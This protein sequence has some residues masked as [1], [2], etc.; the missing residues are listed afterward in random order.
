MSLVGLNKSSMDSSGPHRVRGDSRS[1][2]NSLASVDCGQT[3]NDQGQ[4]TRGAMH[5][6]QMIAQAL[7]RV[8]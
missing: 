5:I 3:S 1:R 8:T 6:L 2:P 4:E 7:Q